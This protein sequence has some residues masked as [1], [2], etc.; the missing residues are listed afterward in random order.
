MATSIYLG[1]P[2]ANVVRWIEENCNNQKITRVV[3]EGHE[4]EADT[5]YDGGKVMIEG[6]GLASA[7]ECMFTATDKAGE[8]HDM[9]H[10]HTDPD[11]TATDTLVT[12][13]ATM[14]IERMRDLCGQAGS[15]LDIDA[16]ITI[17]LTLAD[18]TVLNYKVAIGGE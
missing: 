13:D 15:S 3:S 11:F 6:K 10:V 1:M 5:L 16:G 9:V 2:P 14:L 4:S 17:A 18:G 7:T 8:K 12:I